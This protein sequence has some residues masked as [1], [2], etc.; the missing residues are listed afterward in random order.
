M[1]HSRKKY[2]SSPVVTE[3]VYNKFVK[4]CKEQLEQMGLTETSEA[5]PILGTAVLDQ[6][7]SVSTYLAKLRAFCSFLISNPQYHAS[8]VIFYPFTPKGT[9]TCQERAVS[10]FLLS[11]FGDKGTPLEDLNVSIFLYAMI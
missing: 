3:R 4:I 10:H 7:N 11:K 2:I 8:L 9:V 5:I 1:V 6:K